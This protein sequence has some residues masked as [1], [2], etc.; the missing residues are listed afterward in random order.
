MNMQQSNCF[1]QILSDHPSQA[2]SRLK[3]PFF[4]V[5]VHI[6]IK[7]FWNSTMAHD[8]AASAHTALLHRY[9]CMC[10]CVSECLSVCVCVCVCVCL[11]VCVCVHARCASLQQ[12]PLPPNQPRSPVNSPLM[13]TFR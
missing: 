5:F 7:V 2:L 3:Y 4:W 10:V 9:S 1:P 8:M 11:C 6:T 13:F 12:R